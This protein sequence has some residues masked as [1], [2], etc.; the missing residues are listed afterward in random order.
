M[1]NIIFIR[2]DEFPVEYSVEVNISSDMSDIIYRVTFIKS[3]TD[4]FT[5]KFEMELSKDQYQI[6]T[7]VFRST[8]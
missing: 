2:P 4:C 3:M 5:Q 8:F 1:D 6:L 7:Q